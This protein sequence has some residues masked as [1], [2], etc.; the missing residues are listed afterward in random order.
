MRQHTHKE[1]KNDASF[2]HDNVFDM[3][4]QII[5]S[6]DGGELSKQKRAGVNIDKTLERR[7]ALSKSERRGMQSKKRL[8]ERR[9]SRDNETS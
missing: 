8:Y 9:K 4:R 6:A 7:D 2:S 3:H 5:G 1:K